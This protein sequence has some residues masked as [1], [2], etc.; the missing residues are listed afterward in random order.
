MG[1][2][3][4]ALGRR[5][6]RITRSDA[7]RIGRRCGAER[8]LLKYDRSSRDSV[9]HDGSPADRGRGRGRRR[10]GPSV[11]LTPVY[12]ERSVIRAEPLLAAPATP[13]LRQRARLA[14]AL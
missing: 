11:L 3:V 12:G 8:Y 14:D 5:D 6:W 9:C 13:L 10:Y 4:V 7:S 2:K 1:L